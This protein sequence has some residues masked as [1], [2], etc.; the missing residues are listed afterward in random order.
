MEGQALDGDTRLLQLVQN[1]AHLAD[2]GDG[3][4]DDAAG[5]LDGG[6]RDGLF[7]FG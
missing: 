2:V 4:T 5:L 7:G 3:H 6:V 1:L